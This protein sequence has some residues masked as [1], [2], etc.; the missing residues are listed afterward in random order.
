MKNKNEILDELIDDNNYFLE[1]KYKEFIDEL[2]E[3]TKRKFGRYI[4]NMNKK[5]VIKNMKDDI[6][7]L[8]YNK[9]YNV[10]ETK[11]NLLLQNL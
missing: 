8:L 5:E 1:E 10:I 6:G 7:L 11:N 4:E 3:P 2:D 9:R